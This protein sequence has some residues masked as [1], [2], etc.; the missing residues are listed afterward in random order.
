[1][2]FVANK[3]LRLEIWFS[4]GALL[5]ASSAWAEHTSY[6]HC[7]AQDHPDDGTNISVYSGESWTGSLSGDFD[8]VEFSEGVAT[9]VPQQAVDFS[10]T[11]DGSSDLPEVFEL[12]DEDATITFTPN[13]ASSGHT[14]LLQVTYCYPACSGPHAGWKGSYTQYA[15]LLN[16]PPQRISDIPDQSVFV[17]QTVVLDLNDYFTDAEGDPLTYSVTLSNG[18]AA[19][20]F[21]SLDDHTLTIAPD[22]TSALQSY[23]I[24]VRVQDGQSGQSADV[25]WVL[26]I[27]NQPPELTSEIPDQA[28]YVNETLA[29]D[30]GDYFTDDAVDDLTYS[31]QLAS[32]NPAPSFISLDGH[33]LTIAP[34]AGTDPAIY[35]IEVSA[36]DS[37]NAASASGSFGVFVVNQ[38]PERISYIPDQSVFVQQTVALDLSAYFTDAEGDPLEYSVS[39]SS[40]DPTPSFI[41]LDDHTLTIAPDDSTDLKSYNIRVRVQDDQGGNVGDTFWVDVRENQP[42]ELTNEIPDQAVYVNQTVA[43]DLSDYFTDDAV[44]DLTYSVQLASGNPAPSFISV[45]DQVLTIAPPADTLL[46]VYNIE[47]SATDSYNAASASGSFDLF[48]QNHPPQRISDIPDQSVFVHQ[49]VELDLND[50]F[51]DAEGDPLTYSV[52]LSNGD[53]APSFISLDDHTLTIAPDDTSALQSYNIRVRVQ[54]D[55]GGLSA[56]VFWVHVI[57]N[58]PPQLVED[59]IPDQPVFVNETLALDL[60]D[61][62]TDDAVDDL[63]YSV[64][65]ASGNPAPSFIS[66]ADQ[67]LTIAPPADTLLGVY[68][69]EVFATD[70]YNAASASGSFDLQV[71]NHPPQRIS[72]IPDQSVFVHQ[73]VELDLNDYF[74]DVEGDPLTYSVTLS[75][76]DVAPSFISLDDHTLTIA[77]DDGTELDSYNIRV[78]VQDGQ[79]GLSEDVFWVGVSENQPPQ[80]TSAIPD[81]DLFV[82]EALDLDLNSY[83]TDDALDDLIYSVDLANGDAAPSFISLDGHTLTFAPTVGTDPG[84]YNIEITATDGYSAASVSGSFN[85][86]VHKLPPQRISDIPDQT[87][88]QGQTT[89]LDLNDYFTDASGDPLAYS[90]SLD[91]GLPAP[92]FISID[93]HILI[94]APDNGS[95]VTSYGIRVSAMDDQGGQASDAFSVT[96]VNPAPLLISEIPDQTVIQGQ[97]VTLD[98]TDYFTDPDD[99]PLDSFVTL[100]NGDAAPSFITQNGPILTIAPDSDSQVTSF[101]IRVEVVD[102]QDDAVSDTFVVTVVSNTVQ[103]I[104]AIPDQTIIQ[105]QTVTLDLTD[106]F[107]DAEGDPLTYSVSLSNGNP[108]PSF[109]SLAGHILT[110]APV[111]DTQATSFGISVAAMNDQGGQA[112]DILSVTVVNPAPQQISEIPDQTVI[113]GQTVTLDLTDYFTDPDG[114][115][116]FYSVSLANGNPAP[117]FISLAGHILTIAP[118]YD[119]QVTSFGI[120][121]AVVDSQSDAV[122]DTFSVTVVNPAPELISEIPDQTVIQGQTVT[123]DLT[124]YFTDPDDDPL[125]SF[126]TL[127]NGDAAPSFITQNGPILTIAPDNDSQVTSFD[128]RVEVVDN[129]YSAVSDTFVVTVVNP[130]PQLI[131]EI[132]DQTVIQGQTVTLDLTDYFT[133]PDDDPLDSFVTLVSGD[134]A[135]SFITQ[136]GPILTIAPDSDSQVTS[137]DIRVEVVDNQDGAVSDTFVVTVVSNPVQLVSEIPDQTVIQEQI[138]TLD[139][140]DYF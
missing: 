75:N 53:A 108:A 139:L 99:D 29:L 130:A 126:V 136:N 125:D 86:F 64:Q 114:D 51:T 133:D 22:D 81:Q 24:R 11:V 135:P 33:T 57:Q 73:T 88:I 102:N 65:L 25:F 18:D 38:P 14:Y 84:L 30:L 15:H 16:Y 23:N 85:L 131:S 36:T 47:V 37:Y 20:S 111:Y 124:D 98:L 128:I 109:I 7:A 34:P 55:Q 110:F 89:T 62:F 78:R 5:F 19:P 71:L 93:G 69:I 100:V 113:Q 27:Q 1:M 82:N 122:L 91:N 74:T 119:T 50:Y 49:T 70:S 44:D 103:L 10:V 140:S 42:P 118:V 35:Y 121:I 127:A 116:L 132:P 83:F 9:H 39:L 17:H 101:D 61:Y 87:V 123:L 56:D 94:I 6:D 120:S 105:D 79:G 96:V 68:N 26:V 95:Q 21:I 137:F 107:T 40:G 104:S 63:T 54:D 138:V 48:V 90:V 13:A 97:T 112:S 129:Q 41:S 2:L 12:N 58:Q 80:L 66:V 92:S 117:S 3:A 52:T 28:V 115:P 60:S 72:D 46:G 67:V 32:G 134:A 45:V 31:V 106:Y 77:P 4:L 8:C 76:G 59:G 43:L